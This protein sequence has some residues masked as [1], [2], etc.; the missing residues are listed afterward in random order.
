MHG[1]REP[2]KGPSAPAAVAS[3]AAR[4]QTS[5]PPATRDSATTTSLTTR[6]AGSCTSRCTARCVSVVPERVCSL[7]LIFTIWPVGSFSTV[8]STGVMSMTCPLRLT[9]GTW[10]E[11]L[12]L[13]PPGVQV[14]LAS[15]C[16][17]C[18]TR[19]RPC[20]PGA[21]SATDDLALTD[22]STAR[23]RSGFTVVSAAG[24]VSPRSEAVSAGEPASSAQ[25]ARSG[26]SVAVLELPLATTGSARSRAGMAT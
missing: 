18:T 22:W 2:V 23:P 20:S 12:R 8:C 24:P 7:N 25:R 1:L 4:S 3:W 14:A 5:L 17:P 21:K 9:S 15:E 16:A 26:L 11:P 10:L 19:L 13:G 6:P